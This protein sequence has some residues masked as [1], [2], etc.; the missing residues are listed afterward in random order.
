MFGRL[1][2]ILARS[3][4][5]RER[6]DALPVLHLDLD[7][8]VGPAVVER[9]SVGASPWPLRGHVVVWVRKLG[10]NA[11]AVEKLSGPAEESH[12]PPL[13]GALEL[14]ADDY[15]EG[16]VGF[17]VG[18]E[19]ERCDHIKSHARTRGA[20]SLHLHQVLRWKVQFD[21]PSQLSFHIKTIRF[22]C[23]LQRTLCRVISNRKLSSDSLRIRL[24]V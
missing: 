12:H 7:D 20:G 5:D 8:A 17:L 11:D 15:S 10:E 2:A 22:S 3:V 21:L 13:R 9:M 16:P 14:A 18:D 24:K 19:G 4:L 23:I 1:E 6:D